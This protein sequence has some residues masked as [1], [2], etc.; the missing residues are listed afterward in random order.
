MEPA[1]AAPAPP[2]AA[3]A[4]PAAREV[5]ILLPSLVAVTQLFGSTTAQTVAVETDS[6]EYEIY[7]GN[8]PTDSHNTP[9]NYT[10]INI[11]HDAAGNG[12]AA[13]ASDTLEYSPLPPWLAAIMFTCCGLLT[14]ATLYGNVLV[15]L[16]IVLVKQLRTKYNALIVS[17]AVSDFLVGLMVMPL[18]IDITYKRSSTWSDAV[19]DFW[20][21]SDVLLC[22]AS[23]LN[24]CAISWVRYI[25]I[26]NPFTFEEI[27]TWRRICAKVAMVW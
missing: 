20:L 25:Q 4:A 5:D 7:T 3:A 26:T 24:L 1:A 10:D 23:I 16:A 6:M 8:L 18:A 2:V 21:T 27:I 9:Y 22:T 19:C 12:T 11:T 15:C 14:F 17:L 13:D